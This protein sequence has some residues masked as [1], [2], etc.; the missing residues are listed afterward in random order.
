MFLGITFCVQL[1]RRWKEK[2]PSGLRT[3]CSSKTTGPVQFWIPSTT[4]EKLEGAASFPLFHISGNKCRLF[5]FSL[6]TPIPSFTCAHTHSNL[7]GKLWSLHVLESQHKS[8]T[9]C[10]LSS[11]ST[12]Q[13]RMSRDLILCPC[14]YHR[15][16]QAQTKP[17]QTNHC[18]GTN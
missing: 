16:G 7:T 10:A 17:P 4:F 15:A 2:N 3:E 12:E 5:F 13:R 18:S 14:S 6:T 1:C 11:V 9:P 8:P